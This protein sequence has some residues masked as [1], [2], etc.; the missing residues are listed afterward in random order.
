MSAVAE[1]Y[2]ITDTGVLLNLFFVGSHVYLHIV[3]TIQAFLILC[4]AFKA[5]SW[6]NYRL[7]PPPLWLYSHSS[8]IMTLTSLQ[9]CYN[10]T[11]LLFFLVT[12]KSEH[13]TSSHAGAHTNSS[14]CLLLLKRLSEP[15]ASS[16]I[17]PGRE[18]SDPRVASN[19]DSLAKKNAWARTHKRGV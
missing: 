2:S 17:E 5:H 6:S 9:T 18:W 4:N 7:H 12:Y 13:K 11:P 19:T 3:P 16:R 10:S 8:P 15:I 1:R 14:V